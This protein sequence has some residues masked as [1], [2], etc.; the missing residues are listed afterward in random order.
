M[1]TNVKNRK[2][3]SERESAQA[4]SANRRERGCFAPQETDKYS[5]LGEDIRCIPAVDLPEGNI[6]F[7]Q[8]IKDGRC[9]WD[10]SNVTEIDADSNIDFLSKAAEAYCRVHKATFDFVKTDNPRHDLWYLLNL[11]NSCKPDNREVNIDYEENTNRLCF[12]EYEMCEFDYNTF[13]FIPV[14]FYEKLPENLKPIVAEA[15]GYL[16]TCCNLH[17]PED[18]FD[19]SFALGDWGEETLEELSCEAEDQEYAKEYRETMESYK[20]GSISRTIKALEVYPNDIEALKKA[21][22][23]KIPAYADLKYGSLLTLML[24]GIELNEND[25]ISNYFQTPSSSTLEDFSDK[26]SIMNFERLF[27]IV[28]DM[29]D[30]I[31]ERAMCAINDE[32]G[33]LEI[34]GLYEYRIIDESITEEM[35]MSH[36]PAKWCEW[37]HKFYSAIEEI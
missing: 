13:F 10:I 16:I 28:Y 22:R 11:I 18:H 4:I 1:A 34:E 27:A 8:I 30:P 20:S 9:M 37:F 15:M 17:L 24:E 21:I 7:G 29:M 5:F 32:A 35:K 33:S 3:L 26:E 36:F 12:V 25:R 19:L 2:N 14:H 6:P 31:A 23:E